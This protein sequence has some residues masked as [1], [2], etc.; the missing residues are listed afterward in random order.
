M[1]MKPSNYF[2]IHL[3]TLMKPV[4]SERHEELS[5]NWGDY[6]SPS[7]RLQHSFDCQICMP[8]LTSSDEIPRNSLPNRL[9]G[10]IRIPIL[11]RQPGPLALPACLLKQLRSPNS[12]HF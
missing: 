8:F 6:L 7:S 12:S 9:M 4:R 2:Y 10:I 11:Y 5:G 3:I 1:R